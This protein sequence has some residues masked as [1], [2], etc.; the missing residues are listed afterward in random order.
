MKKFLI[1]LFL[2]SARLLH[3]QTATIKGV[4]KDSANIPL[5]DIQIVVLEEPSYQTI[6][7]SK[8]EYSLNVPANRKINIVFFNISYK[9]THKNPH[10][11]RQ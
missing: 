8:G 7:N 5:A 3:S 2:L 6:T 10:T 4:V 1:L 9:K 11:E